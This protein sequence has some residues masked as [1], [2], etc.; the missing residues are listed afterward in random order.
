MDDDAQ[1]AAEVLL[2]AYRSGLVQLHVRAPAFVLEGGERPSV[3]PLARWQAGQGPVVTTLL[4]TSIEVRDPIGLQMLQLLDGT[5]DRAAL[6]DDLLAFVQQSG[7]FNGP[8]GAP[9]SDHNEIRRILTD[10]IEQ[11]LRKIAGWLFWWHK[12]TASPARGPVERH[13][14]HTGRVR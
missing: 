11:N 8:D 4:H 14:S 6:R 10:E 5:R 12:S 3:S 7:P 9:I 1:G 13:R 2:A